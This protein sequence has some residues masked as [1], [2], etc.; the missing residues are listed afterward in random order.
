MH[1][2]ILS[3]SSTTFDLCITA[4]LLTRGR[5][6]IAKLHAAVALA[7]KRPRYGCITHL[8][9][10]HRHM[11][12]RKSKGEP[13]RYRTLIR[14]QLIGRMKRDSSEAGARH[15][16]KQKDSRQGAYGV[17]RSE[18]S[19]DN[20]L[21]CKRPRWSGRCCN[22]R[23]VWELDPGATFTHRILILSLLPPACLVSMSVVSVYML[24]VP[25]YS[26]RKCSLAGPGAGRDQGKKR[27][28]KEENN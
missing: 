17:L 13:T 1:K 10:D 2:S 8:S 11:N 4:S 9:R 5:F 25:A 7:R 28:G 21:C 12:T 6:R 24:V 14:W 19:S 18:A 26:V 15:I 16:T 27:G 20:A 3:R 23:Q 22:R